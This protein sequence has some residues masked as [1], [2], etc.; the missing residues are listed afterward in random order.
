MM[1]V[2]YYPETIEENIA[3]DELLLMKAEKGEVGETLRFWESAEY[4][5]VLGRAGRAEEEC[6]Q[7]KC[8][9]DG[10]KVA[11]RVSGG[12]TVLQG[13]GCLNYSV[14]LSYDCDER[15]S[16]IISSYECVLGEIASVFSAKGPDVEFFPVCDLAVGGRKISGNAQARKRK[17][18]LH[19][20]T[21]LYDFDLKKISRYLKMP[22][23]EPEYRSGRPH[24]SFVTNISMTKDA[25]EDSVKQVLSF[26]P[27]EWFPDEETLRELDTLIAD[28]YSKDDWNLVF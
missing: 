17:Y 18:F 4:S 21:F 22:P 19:H 10:V 20:G 6:F 11:R 26:T 1:L 23:K 5:V 7:D 3:L 27:D 13:P 15:Y 9:D 28:K 16:N 25:L 8:A 12:G 24:E 14:V 2:K